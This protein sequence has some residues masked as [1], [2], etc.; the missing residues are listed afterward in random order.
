MTA[1]SSS[2]KGSH[3]WGKRPAF[4]G[5]D[6]QNSPINCKPL[7]LRSARSASGLVLETAPPS[8]MKTVREIL[9]VKS[10][11]MLSTQGPDLGYVIF[12][13]KPPPWSCLRFIRMGSSLTLNVSVLIRPV[14]IYTRASISLKC[15]IAIEC[16]H[17][18]S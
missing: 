16:K 9:M 3:K 13:Q 15:L 5:L 6:S 18:F 11:T 7:L 1:K 8:T 10:A 14:R 17:T 12:F 2:S 4:L